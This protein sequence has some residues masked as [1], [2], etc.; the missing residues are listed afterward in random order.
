[1]EYELAVA[2]VVVAA[3]AVKV[4]MALGTD[5]SFSVL[6]EVVP[7]PVIVWRMEMVKDWVDKAGW[8][9]NTGSVGGL[10]RSHTVVPA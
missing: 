5:T 9:E 8:Q 7:A 3:V 1:M 2:V 4:V 10:G 6:L